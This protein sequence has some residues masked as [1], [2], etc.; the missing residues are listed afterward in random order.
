MCKSCLCCGNQKGHSLQTVLVFGVAKKRQ[1]TWWRYISYRIYA[2]AHNCLEIS[3]QL[4]LMWWNVLNWNRFQGTLFFVTDVV[5]HGETNFFN[6][7]QCICDLLSLSS[8][9]S[10]LCRFVYFT[11]TCAMVHRWLPSG[12]CLNAER[13]ACTRFCHNACEGLVDFSCI[14]H[15]FRYV[16]SMHNLIYLYAIFVSS[17]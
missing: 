16:F 3:Y 17:L 12:Y 2:T 11:L 13:I 4:P 15:F 14:F 7:W 9:N 6:Y 1:I 10:L 8:K 5:L